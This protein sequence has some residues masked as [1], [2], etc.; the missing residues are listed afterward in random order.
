MNK[1]VDLP[2]III[3]GLLTCGTLL[4]LFTSFQQIPNVSMMIVSY[5]MVLIAIII[6]T[7]KHVTNFI[8]ALGSKQPNLLHL[9]IFSLPYLLMVYNK[10]LMIHMLNKYKDEITHNLVS[11]EYNT[12]SFIGKIINFV[13]IQLLTSKQTDPFT[14]ALLLLMAVLHY[15]NTRILYTVL[16]TNNIDG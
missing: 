1:N 8:N 9:F 11:N 10:I 12:Y 16:N 2:N 6:M 3:N 7:I 13:Q 15:V 5:A 4:L 14:N